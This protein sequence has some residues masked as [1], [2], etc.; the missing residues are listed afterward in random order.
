MFQYANNVLQN[1]W[2]LL[3]L[4]KVDLKL[5]V[6]TTKLGWIWWVLDP[7]IMMTIY[8]FMVGVVFQR[9]GDDYHLFALTG[10][11]SW[12][13]FSRSLRKVSSSIST[14]SSLLV[15]TSIPLEIFTIAPAITQCFFAV[16][17]YTIIIVWVC[18]G[19]LINS[20]GG[21]VTQLIFLF[22]HVIYCSQIIPLVFLILLFSYAIGL[23]F[24]I[25]SVFI[26]DL[27]KFID[28]ALRGGFFLTPI[29]YSASRVMDSERIPDILKFV[30]SLNPMGWIITSMRDVILEARLI[31]FNAYILFLIVGLVFVQLAIML[32]RCSKIKLSKYL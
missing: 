15:N 22:N 7:L 17:G 1:R 13:F 6:S 21:V 27:S 16:V 11:V 23:F 26:S 25:V 12:S 20:E 14:N 2:A 31:N 4:T 8:Y 24:A 3:A 10:I 29:L 5:T 30:Y 19:A 18:I 9:G 32:L 28:Y